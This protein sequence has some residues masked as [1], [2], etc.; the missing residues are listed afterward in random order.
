MKILPRFEIKRGRKNTGQSAGTS[1]FFLPIKNE[2]NQVVTNREAK[3][4]SIMAV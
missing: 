1:F 2:E 3:D 4:N